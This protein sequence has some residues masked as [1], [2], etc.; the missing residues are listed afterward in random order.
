MTEA[1]VPDY[2][3]APLRMFGVQMDP[4]RYWHGLALHRASREHSGGSC[5]NCR[6]A[7]WMSAVLWRAPD[8][9]L[10]GP[11]LLPAVAWHLVKKCH[12]PVPEAMS[13]AGQVVWR[14]ANYFPFEVFRWVGWYEGGA[15]A[16]LTDD[17]RHTLS[18]ILRLTSPPL[19]AFPGVPVV[20]PPA[21]EKL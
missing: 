17:E 10:K 14:V 1:T 18:V 9:A 5:W 20:S 19:H 4:H 15:F 13:L 3:Y 8:F 2:P 6:C 11:D 12:Y 21:A 16:A 7:D